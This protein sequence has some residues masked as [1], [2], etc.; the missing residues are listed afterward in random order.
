M[1]VVLAV[2]GAGAAAWLFIGRN[3]GKTGTAATTVASTVVELTIPTLPAPVWVAPI[4]PLPQ[5]F[6]GPGVAYAV[7]EPLASGL[8]SATAKPYLDFAQQ[9]FDQLAADDW[10]NAL[11]HFLVQPAGGVEGTVTVDQ[12]Q[13]YWTLSDRLSLL[14]IDAVVDPNGVGYDLRVGAVA[15]I[16]DGTTSV[17]CGHLY[18]ELAPNA[19]VVQRGAFITA[20]EGEPWFQPE[21]FLGQPARIAAMQAACP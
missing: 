19:R 13:T 2:I 5:V 1:A 3:D 4:P 10:T 8:P 21:D 15:N 9:V 11:T 18:V 16:I 17:A 6:T 20:A 14:L 12:L 7:S